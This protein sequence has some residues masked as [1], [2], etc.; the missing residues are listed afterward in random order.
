MKQSN[1][2]FVYAMILFT[3]LAVV[4]SGCKTGESKAT[5]NEDW[6]EK[7]VVGYFGGDDP[8]EVLERNE[9]FKAYLEERLGVEVEVFTGTSYN[10]VIEGMRAKRVDA[11]AVGPF[12]YILAAEEAGAEALGV[13]VYSREENPVYDPTLPSHYRSIIFTKKGSGIETLDDL[14][15]KDFN[16]VYPASTSSHLAPKTVLIKAGL[17]PDNDMDTVFAGSHPT[18]VISVWNDKADAGATYESNLYN[19][20]KEGQIEFCGFED[21]KMGLERSEEDLKKLYDECPE[22]HIVMIAMS[23]PIPSTPFAIR[24]DLP[25]SFKAAV[26]EALLDIKDNP[27]LISQTARWYVDPSDELGLDHLD[28]YYNGLRDIAKLLDLDLHEMK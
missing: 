9:P 15:G 23:F 6:P 19:L 10:A 14:P 27:D 7:F 4:V 24:G 2:T 13:G 8:T 17:D 16:F 28:H 21:E 18:S 5:T 25:E 20:A 26:K 22:G 11:M 12:S 3:L 1:R